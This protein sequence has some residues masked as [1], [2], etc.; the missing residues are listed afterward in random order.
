MRVL[1]ATVCRL[2]ETR[3]GLHAVIAGDVYHLAPGGQSLGLFTYSF[4]GF[5]EY[6]HTPWPCRCVL[7]RCHCDITIRDRVKASWTR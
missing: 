5:L 1:Q 7:T 3:G 2:A 4:A 6:N